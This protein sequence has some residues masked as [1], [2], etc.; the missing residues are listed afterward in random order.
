M[1][2]GD[3]VQMKFW[4]A[5]DSQHE[6]A[7]RRQQCFMYPGVGVVVNIHTDT[8]VTPVEVLWPS[9]KVSRHNK[10]WMEKV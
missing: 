6:W 7:Q 5:E 10:S 9:G 8:R 3:L 4:D 1:K 2:A